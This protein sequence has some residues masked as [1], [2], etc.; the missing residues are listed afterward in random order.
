MGLVRLVGLVVGAGGL[1]EDDGVGGV[2]GVG[3]GPAPNTQGSQP[4]RDVDRDG[5]GIVV[6]SDA[7]HA[8]SRRVLVS[9]VR[10]GARMLLSLRSR[11]HVHAARG[12]GGVCG[13]RAAGDALESS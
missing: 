6:H 12:R 3:G 9:A 5:R 1:L 4:Q 2:G 11:A 10:L 13:L 8:L 7:F